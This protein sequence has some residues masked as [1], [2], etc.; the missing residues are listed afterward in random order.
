MLSKWKSQA[1]RVDKKPYFDTFHPKFATT[2]S[3]FSRG[4]P[5]LKFYSG[6]MY[7]VC[8]VRYNVDTDASETVISYLFSIAYGHIFG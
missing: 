8:S 1:Q 5:T 2:H 3:R 4:I 7:S 6:Y